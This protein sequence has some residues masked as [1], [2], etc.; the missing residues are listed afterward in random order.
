MHEPTPRVPSNLN[1]LSLALLESL[2]GE[3]AAAWIVLGGGVA[4][5]HYL[6]FRQTYD[7]DAWWERDLPPGAAHN[8][9]AL[10]RARMNELAAAQGLEVNERNWG[11]THSLELLRAGRKV[12]SF[13]IAPRDIA[14]D[15]SREAEWSPLRLESFLENL[16]AKMKALVNRGAPRDFADVTALCEAGYVEPAECWDLWLKKTP[17]GNVA[18]AKLAVLRTLEQI[19]TRRPLAQ[20]TDDMNRRAAARVRSFI[21]HKFCAIS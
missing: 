19:V 18:E 10:L 12:F 20:I 6:E 13:Q 15:P 2:R 21:R 11:D 4:L 9:I 14:L 1:P 5:S 3:P 17:H 16:A 8:A 7:L